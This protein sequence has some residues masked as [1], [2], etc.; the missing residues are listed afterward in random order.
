VTDDSAAIRLP[1]ADGSLAHA[2][3]HAGGTP[4]H[5]TAQET[6]EEG[7]IQG[8]TPLDRAALENLPVCSRLDTVIAH[9]CCIVARLP[10]LTVLGRK[11]I[12]L[13]R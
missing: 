3:D 2:C 11:E 9:V 13:S 12:L 8:L 7:G 10:R 1:E 6:N 5:A 4:L